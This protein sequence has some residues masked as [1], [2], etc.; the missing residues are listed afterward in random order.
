MNEK[1]V[2]NIDKKCF[3]IIKKYCNKNAL[4]MSRWLTKLALDHIN[5][6]EQ[7]IIENDFNNSS[8]PP[9][10]NIIKQYIGHPEKFK[11]YI[12]NLHKKLNIIKENK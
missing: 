8:L 5:L 1:R 3:D 6:C 2:V 7:E 12:D 9:I 10:E 4:N 11:E